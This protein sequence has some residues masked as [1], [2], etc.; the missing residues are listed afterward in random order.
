MVT[1]V[2]LTLWELADQLFLLHFNPFR[3]EDYFRALFILRPKRDYSRSAS[4][5]C[6]E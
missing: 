5:V 2:N 3:P 1:N 6:L 4:S